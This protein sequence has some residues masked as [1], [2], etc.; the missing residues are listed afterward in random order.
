MFVTTFNSPEPNVNRN[1]K[2]SETDK[3]LFNFDI[4][5][6]ACTSVLSRD[7]ATCRRSAHGANSRDIGVNLPTCVKPWRCTF[8]LTMNDLSQMNSHELAATCL[9]PDTTT[10]PE[11][12]WEKKTRDIPPLTTTLLR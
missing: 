1:R 5:A 3:N 12:T 4:V 11:S 2:R 10:V 6:C 7:S 8:Q 9:I